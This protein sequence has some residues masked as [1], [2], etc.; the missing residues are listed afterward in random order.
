MTFEIEKAIQSLQAS[1]SSTDLD[2]IANRILLVLSL[3]WQRSWLPLVNHRISD[4]TIAY[5][6]LSSLE[7]TG[8]FKGTDEVTPVIARI[9]YTM[10]LVFL[11]IINRSSDGQEAGYR[12]IAPFL[13]EGQESTFNSLRNAQRQ[14]SSITYL[15]KGLPKVWWLD[16]RRYQEMIYRGTRI[17]LRQL[18][19][20]LAALE[21]RTQTMWEEDV[22]LG[23]KDLQV[24]YDEIHD[25][26]ACTE[27]GYSFLTDPR[28]TCFSDKLIL[29]RAILQNRDQAS[30]LV[31]FN[32]NGVLRFNVLAGRAWLTKYAKF[33][34]HLLLRFYLTGGSPSRGTS[35]MAML[36]ENIPT[37][38]LRNLVAFG[39]YVSLNC[40]YSKTSGLSGYDKIIPHALDAFTA[41]LLIQELAIARPFAKLMAKAC[42]PDQP[43][44][45]SLFDKH[46]FVNHN[47]LFKTDDL[48]HA[49]EKHSAEF[50][51]IELGVSDWRHVSA[52]FRNK[53]C[54]RLEEL[55][56]DDDEHESIGALQMGHS[57]QTENRVYGI[58]Q[59]A[60]HGAPE[61]V[62]PLFLDASTDWQVVCRVVPGG[63]SLRYRDAL[64]PMFDGLVQSG[65]ISATVNP[66]PS[67]ESLAAMIQNLSSQVAELTR[68]VAMGSPPSTKTPSMTPTLTVQQMV[69]TEE[70]ALEALRSLLRNPAAQWKTDG[71]RAAIMAV[72][73]R[74][75]DVVAVL[76]TNAGKSMVAIVPPML[77]RDSVT[78]LILPLRVLILD[79]ERKLREMGVSFVT[80]DTNRP[81]IEL[82]SSNIILISADRV[83][84]DSWKQAIL[85]LHQ[86]RP[87]ARMVVDEAHIPLLSQD[88][89]HALQHM[90][91]IRTSMPIQLVLLTASAHDALLEAM[92]SDYQTEPG[93]IVIRGPPN[94]PELRYV[95]RPVSNLDEIVRIIRTAIQSE[96][97]GREDRAMVFVPW[98]ELGGQLEHKLSY[99]F[100]QGGEENREKHAALYQSWLAGDPPVMIA[101]SAFGTGNDYAHVRL[102]VHA[103]APYEMTY[104]VQEVSR[105][106]R[107]GSSALC[108]LLYK[109]GETRSARK[110]DA[111]DLGGRDA[112]SEAMQRPLEKCIR[113]R[114]TS[115]A[116]PEQGAH[117][118]SDPCN[119]TCGCCGSARKQR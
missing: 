10:R 52:A 84:W 59:E 62:L 24:S 93:A 61:D 42:Y 98:K 111:E 20:L 3:V 41:D 70:A 25:D 8:K 112:M 17:H 106:G 60:L 48:T 40:T 33:H 56:E 68:M 73:E 26:L 47:K 63:L 67:T 51:D 18:H 109:S 87:V 81:F 101:T 15:S 83:K 19:S 54:G 74:E 117:C 29:L 119:Q 89:R 78:V 27:V 53:L 107:D 79:F 92:R 30:R 37:Y 38:P 86:R 2:I 6:A 13:L 45:C 16:R 31:A 108:L 14:A 80:Y 90:S 110:G 77:E 35:L 71:Q 118:G 116:D 44:V 75:H 100:Y 104:Y 9:E 4:P 72:L 57:R 46:V 36:L 113:Y 94:R 22:L 96:V 11:I 85:V 43:D 114:I 28:N 97:R 99:P 102:V 66:N 1:L 103:Y 50:M 34:L 115:Y 69:F 55:I 23:L 32:A 105:A 65:R 82:G 12:R 58:S 39:P 49:L 5:L 91:D 88:F 7:P 21:Q 76:P 64:M 95:W